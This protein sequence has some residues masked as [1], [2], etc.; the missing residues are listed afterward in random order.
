MTTRTLSEL[1]FT[2]QPADVADMH[3]KPKSRGWKADIHPNLRISLHKVKSNPKTAWLICP[4]KGRQAQQTDMPGRI[5]QTK[6]WETQ[7]NFDCRTGLLT[8]PG[9][10]MADDKIDELKGN[11]DHSK[12]YP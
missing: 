7:G 11:S 3:P 5:G 9:F 10:H 8:N 6:G 12:A 2:T 1:G 4:Q